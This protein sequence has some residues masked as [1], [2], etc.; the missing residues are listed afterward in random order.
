MNRH[1]NFDLLRLLAAAGVMALHIA[2]LSGQASLAFLYAVDAKL[3]LTTFFVI[4]GYLVYMSYERATSLADYALKRARR[5][6]PAYAA[7]V[8]LCAVLGVL[9][10]TLPAREYFGAGWWQYLAANLSFLNFLQPSLP[11]VFSDNPFPGAPV[12][13]ALWTIK[14]ELMFYAVVPVLAYLVRRWG[15][16]AVLGLGFVLACLWW[17]GCVHLAQRTGKSAFYELAKQLP[18]QLMY[19]LPGV[20]AY[21]ERV[22][23]SRWGWR[24]GAGGLVALILAYQFDQR[25]VSLGVFLY[26]L[27]LAACVFWA[28]HNLRYLGSVTRNGD[29]SYGIYILHFPVIQTIV[30]FGVFKASPWAGLALVL[31]VVWGLA[32]LSWHLIEAPALRRAGVGKSATTL[33]AAQRPVL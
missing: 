32:M 18:G 11:G 5:I 26:P 16:H 12:N 28:A 27:A 14:V 20:W 29:V 4:S 10:T 9:V 25:T 23:L 17:A 22:R 15:H 1:N 6:V 31:L 13:G 21:C 7:V 3:A 24:L 33:D 19:F 2:D 30:H 8:L